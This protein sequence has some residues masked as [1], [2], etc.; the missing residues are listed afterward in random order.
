VGSGPSD[1][2][3]TAWLAAPPWVK[4]QALRL[5]AGQ[6]D[7]AAH[8][9]R[10]AEGRNRLYV[11]AAGALA[12]AAARAAAGEQRLAEVHSLVTSSSTGFHLPGWAAD[13]VGRL[14]LAASTVRIPLTEAGAVGGVLALAQA[15]D[16]V[17][18]SAE[19]ALVVAI[20]LPS[21]LPSLA[22][23][24][25]GD[26]RPLDGAGAAY[27]APDQAPGLAIVDHATL[28][29]PQT[30]DAFTLRL[31][32]G[33]FGARIADDLAAIVADPM[34]RAIRRL[35]A[36]HGLEP[37]QLSALLLVPGSAPLVARLGDA[38][39][40]T[41]APLRWAAETP[42]IASLSVALQFELLQRYLANR[43]RPR[44]WAVLATFG[45]G[46][47]IALLLLRDLE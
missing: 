10:T 21:L 43:E 44:G 5:A 24:E 45:P 41:P 7:K 30:R 8:L 33:G 6:D 23:D 40:L 9:L 47:T 16:R 14:P 46:V 4:R 11:D 26:G 3:R 22:S 17:R 2:D 12:E 25:P 31:A 19:P 27:L 20:E 37:R 36:R 39:D 29:L 32:D 35:V 42:P 15:S 34:A 18:L 28:L 1:Q 38:L 13:L